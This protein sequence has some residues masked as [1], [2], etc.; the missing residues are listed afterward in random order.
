[1]LH[2]WYIYL[3]LG[4]FRVNVVKYSMHGA[5]GINS[6]VDLSIVFCSRLP[7]RVIRNLAKRPT[8]AR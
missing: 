6:M 8:L 3:H 1:M 2:V 4:D 5:Y 7:G